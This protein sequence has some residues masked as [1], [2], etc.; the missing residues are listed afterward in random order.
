MHRK[1]EAIS[2]SCTVLRRCGTASRKRKPTLGMHIPEA[3][4]KTILSA[5]IALFALAGPASALGAKEFYEQVD[6]S[7][8]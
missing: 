6:R 4:M 7:H 2:G 3:S 1:R 5:R 8:F